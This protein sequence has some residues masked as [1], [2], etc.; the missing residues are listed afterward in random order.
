VEVVVVEGWGGSGKSLLLSYLDSHSKVLALPM[1]DKIVY[2][3]LE[4]PN[5]KLHAA[6]Q[7]IRHIRSCL[8]PHRYYN[9]E[10]NGTRRVIPVLLSTLKD[11]IINIPLDFDFRRFEETWK[12]KVIRLKHFSRKQLLEI[13]YTSFFKCVET[14]YLRPIESINTFVTMGD[15][16]SCTPLQVLRGYEG[17]KIVYV[18]RSVTE[19]IA[20]RSNRKTPTGLTPEMF[21]KEFST[22]ILSGEIQ[23]IINYERLINKAKR[24][25]PDKIYIIDFDYLLTDKENVLREL[26]AFLNL[27]AESLSP[28]LLGYPLGNNDDNYGTKKNDEV[29]TLLTRSQIA[30]IKSLESLGNSGLYVNMTLLIFIKILNLLLRCYRLISK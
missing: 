20:I 28:S 27:E 15:A 3:L 10:Y 23:R 1:H 9:I 19:L 6:D 12:N 5:D 2:D 7:D 22:V 21:E 11:D 16:K 26:Q 29:R 24:S 14:K 17:V 4:L 13:F 25:F 18:K 30:L 8:S